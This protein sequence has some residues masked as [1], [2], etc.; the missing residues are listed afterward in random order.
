[1]ETHR[2][3]IATKLGLRTQAELIH[4]ALQNGM[5]MM[6]EIRSEEQKNT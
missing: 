5:L 6:E 4:F 3:H 1:V 2:A